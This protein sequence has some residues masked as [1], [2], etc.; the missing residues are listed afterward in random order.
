MLWLVFPLSVTSVAVRVPSFWI[1]PPP[2]RPELLSTLTRFSVNV[3]V[4][5]Q[6]PPPSWPIPENPLRTVRSLIVTLP[7]ASKMS[8]MRSAFWPS[9]IVDVAPAPVIVTGKTM[10]RSPVAAE[11]SSA[12]VTVRL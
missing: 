8:K 1:A 12:P 4:E 7:A 3:V 9:R 2:S 11:S 10:S 6:M 5:F